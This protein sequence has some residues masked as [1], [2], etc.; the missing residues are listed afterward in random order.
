LSEWREAS[1][2]VI[3]LGNF[4]ACLAMS[5]GGL[6]FF[7]FIPSAILALALRSRW[8]NLVEF[9][10][11]GALGTLVSLLVIQP[12]YRFATSSIVASIIGLP[13]GFLVPLALT[14]LIIFLISGLGAMVGS[15][16]LGKAG[17]SRKTA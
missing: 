8:I 15:S 2:P 11:T 5:L 14:L 1:R 7:V 16:L 10:I 12:G 6:W 13:E 17:E 3:L 4:L 9:G